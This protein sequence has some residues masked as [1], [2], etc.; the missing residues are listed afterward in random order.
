MFFFRREPEGGLVLTRKLEA[1][2]TGPLSDVFSHGLEI[3]LLCADQRGMMVVL[4]FLSKVQGSCCRTRTT[5]S[6]SRSALCGRYSF[7]LCQGMEATGFFADE[8]SDG[9]KIRRPDKKQRDAFVREHQQGS[10]QL[11][12]PRTSIVILSKKRPQSSDST[13]RKSPLSVAHRCSTPL[14]DPGQPFDDL[15][16]RHPR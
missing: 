7:L 4:S 16:P 10:R 12:S 9:L 15:R 8:A 3:P 5:S 1:R 2:G 6:S 11:G 14:D 13:S